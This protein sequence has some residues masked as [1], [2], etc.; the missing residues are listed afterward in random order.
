MFRD[1]AEVLR[2][3]PMSGDKVVPCRMTRAFVEQYFDVEKLKAGAVPRA[4]KP[5]SAES[6]K[7][8]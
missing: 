7:K 3:P 2:A 6:K 4:D 5:R 8:K 1:G